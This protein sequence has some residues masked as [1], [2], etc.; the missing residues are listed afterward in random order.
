MQKKKKN[1]LGIGVLSH[2]VEGKAKDT[3]YFFFIIFFD[4]F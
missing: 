1:T 2:G 4:I 3:C